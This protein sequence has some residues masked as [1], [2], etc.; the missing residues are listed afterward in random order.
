MVNFKHSFKIISVLILLAITFSYAGNAP[1]WSAEFDTPILWQRTTSLGNFVVSTSDGL[2]GLDTKTG[3]KT[4]SIKSLGNLTEGAYEEIPNTPFIS[5]GKGNNET[6]FVEP[7]EG[8]IIFSSA[9]AGLS[10]VEKKY[11][12]Y[13]NNCVLVTGNAV[14]DKTLKMVMVDMA[15]GKVLWTKGSEFGVISSLYELETG[16]F[17]ISTLFYFY[18]I[19]IKTGAE[20][21]KNVMDKRMKGME[22][23]FKGLDKGGANLKG[24]DEPLLRMFHRDG[25]ETFYIAYEQKQTTTV[26]NQTA[27]SY[28]TI[29]NSFSVNDGNQAWPN[30]VEFQNTHIG[31]VAFDDKGLII[32]QNNLNMLDYKTGAKLWGKKGKGIDVKGDALRYDYFKEG[33]LITSGKQGSTDNY[34]NI[35]DAN[36]G[37]FKFEKFL[38]LNGTIQKQQQIDKGLLVI[39][40]E[41][42]NIINLTTGQFYFDPPIK[43]KGSLTVT[44]GNTLYAV[45]TK[46]DFVYTVDLATA[47]SK[48]LSAVPVKFEGKEDAKSIEVKGSSIIV[49]SDQNMAAF[50]MSGKLLFN[51][52]YAAPQLPGLTRALLYANAVRAAYV[53][54][55]AGMASGV[56]GAASASVVVKPGDVNAA[57]TKGLTQ[58]VSQMYGDISKAGI[59][60]ATKAWQAAEQRF[61]ASAEATDFKFMLQAVDKKQNVL[62]KVSKTDGSK[63]D[64][65]SLGDDKNPGYEVDDIDKRVYFR[66]T[67]KKIDC[68]QF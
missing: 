7:F 32:Y 10:K 53:G 65:I 2:Y 9:D 25:D 29:F 49:S 61:K 19:N 26:N 62:I 28:N 33:I 22:G 20:V 51:K 37:A 12:L 40:D 43:T 41:E 46:D 47:T 44:V 35:L 31:P 68:Y 36:A 27:I 4:W 6:Y 42:L 59:S 34:V 21:F 60:Y 45:N 55:V 16:D 52:Y 58:G 57:M 39:T 66:A 11:F 13:K 14:G 50:D 56:Y 15:T 24:N 38:R 18:K 48:K 30:T 67:P 17:L 3:K 64:V 23:L 54:V 1:V 5:V 8:K 63:T